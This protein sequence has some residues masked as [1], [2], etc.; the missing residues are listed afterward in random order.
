M[1]KERIQELIN[2]VSQIS[3]H[4]TIWWQLMNRP[5][6]K[7]YQRVITADYCDFFL[8]VATALEKA[9]HIGIWQLFETKHLSLQTVVKGLEKSDSM[10]H[11]ELKAQ[12]DAHK[13]SLVKVF[14]IRSEVHAHR[15]LSVEPS[16]SYSRCK[17]TPREMKNLV[18]LAQALV[19]SLAENIGIAA[20][21]EIT[22]CFKQ[23]QKLAQEHTRQLLSSLSR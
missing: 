13:V 14:S 10:L 19:S 22:D 11:H 9:F 16:Q 4:Y 3:C 8:P 1:K 2:D 17:L 7:A 18:G 15:S 5:D 21:S 12:I 20:K 23:R 6:R